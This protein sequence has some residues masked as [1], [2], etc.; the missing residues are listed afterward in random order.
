MEIAKYNDMMA[1]L[2]RKGLASGT[3][4]TQKVP[5]PKPPKD[6]LELFKEKSDILLQASFASTNKDYFNGLIQQE[7]EKARKSGVSAEDALDFL[8]QQSK[9]YRTL[10]EEGR[11]QGEPA[12]LGS[13]YSYGGRV[14]FSNGSD[15]A[16]YKVITPVTEANLKNFKFPKDHKY[17]VQI[18]TNEKGGLKTISA[19]TK[20]ELELEI[21]KSPITNRDYREGL[22]KT[23][24]PE[25]AIEFDK[26]RIKIPTGEFIGEGRDR[27][28]IFEIRNKDGTNPKY[29]AAKAGGG[30]KKLYNSI[31][32]VKKA[33]LDFI[34][35]ELV[36]ESVERIKPNINEIIYRNKKTGEIIKKYKPFV[37]TE[38]TTIPGQGV[39]TLEEAQKFVDDYKIKNPV[40]QAG[41]K[42]LNEKLI[43]LFEDSRI[44]KILRTG[45]PSAKD[46]DIVKDIIGGTDRQ[47]QE[48]LAQLAD[49]VDPKGQRTIDGIPKIDGKKAKNIFNFHKTKAIAKEL[50]DIAIAKSVGEKKS[51]GTF[52]GSIQSSLPM[53]GG[54]EG[55][56]VDEAK[57][58]AS[59]VRLNSKPYSIFGQVI[60]GDINQGPKQTFDANLSIFEEQVKNAIKNNENPIQAI[61]K[62][63]KRAAEAEAEAN[64][65]KSRNT[66]KVYF[67]RITTDSPDIA[68][69]NK[70][71][72]TKYKKFFDKNYAEQ[73]Y[74]FVIPKD[75]QPLPSLAADLK[76]KNSSTYKNMIKQIKDAG[77]KFIKNIDQL[78]EKQLFEKLKNNPNFKTI[79]RIMPRLVSNDEFLDRRYAFANNIMTDAGPINLMPAPKEDEERTFTERFPIT[80]GVGLTVPSAV[81]VQKAAGIPVLK[82]LANIGKY[83]LKA[84]GSLPGAAY[85]AG[86]T[87]AKR[88][89]EGK[90]IPGAVIDKE[91]GIEL[92]LPEAFKR[93][94][95][96]MMKAARV[97]TP[98]G[99]TITAAGLAKDAYQRAQELKAMSPAQRAEL[100]RIRDDFSFGEYSG[101][102]DGGLMRQGFAEGPKDPGRR[103]FMKIMGGLASLPILGRFF[104]IGEKAAPVI[105][106]VKTEAAKGKPEWFDA[107]VNKVIRMGEDVTDRFATKDR[108]IVNQIDIADGETVRVYRDIDEGAIKVEYESPDNMYGDPVQ[109]Q[110]K[111]PLPDEGNPR[112]T[113][114]FDV[115]ESGPVGRAFGPDDYEIE[116]DEVGG[117]DI[118]D[119]SSDVSKLKEY[120]TGQKP[121]MKEIV[122]NKKRRDKAKAISEGGES[123]MDEVVKRQGEFIQFDD[124][125]PDPID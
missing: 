57:A 38:K 62:Y 18:P 112:P 88:L 49:A 116:I 11:K 67:P 30:Q 50:E 120:A 114:E 25:G 106:A 82:A 48:K 118:K 63:N 124:V 80:T 76:D 3:D 65:Y 13:S 102:K 87:I 74:S 78:D 33:K 70:S 125:N 66:K 56:S 84:V 117:T 61:R 41:T 69:K 34:P 94:G 97:S 7:Y 15:R 26:N 43:S 110:Y 91:V 68:I 16:K 109:L 52:R 85:F 22:I 60:A 2:T 20:K 103:T 14:G 39:D 24:L 107:L 73:G 75:L 51:L 46:L 79:R 71:A 81:A 5:P 104:K 93:F 86:D 29:T 64:L 9:R 105:D 113:A 12:I 36:K 59:S 4:K 31:E 95:P 58:R 115:A 100:A 42:E 44:K 108:E 89:E 83:P 45:R 99:A 1:H 53:E 8:K 10:I 6:P 123:E 96:L 122:Q 92:L 19:K 35:D 21:K 40:I 90:S 32:E 119:L 98:I 54:L 47:A 37:G 17:K 121:T 72:Y 111:K 23:K 27:A 101:A 28:Q 77:R 55:Y